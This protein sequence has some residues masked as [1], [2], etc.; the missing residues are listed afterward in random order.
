MRQGHDFTCPLCHV[1]MTVYADPKS[2]TFD[3]EAGTVRVEWAANQFDHDCRR[4]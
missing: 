1:A 2:F 4:A 3:G